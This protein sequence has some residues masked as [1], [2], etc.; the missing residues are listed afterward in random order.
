MPILS[1][2]VFKDNTYLDKFCWLKPGSVLYRYA[3]YIPNSNKKNYMHWK[4]SSTVLN[5]NIKIMKIWSI[6]YK[7]ARYM[8]QL[9]VIQYKIGL[10]RNAT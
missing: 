8:R 1:S 6:T 7:N 9:Y 3:W 4:Y 2:I 10:Y 5:E